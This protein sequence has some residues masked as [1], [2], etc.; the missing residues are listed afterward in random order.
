MRLFVMV[1]GIMFVVISAVHIAILSI[2]YGGMPDPETHLRVIGI[3]ISASFVIAAIITTL[4]KLSKSFRG[5][6]SPERR[7]T[8]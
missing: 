6:K 5:V 1:W 3:T 7:D 2:A 4:V 8:V